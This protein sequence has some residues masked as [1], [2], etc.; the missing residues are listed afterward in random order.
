MISLGEKVEK[1]DPTAFNQS[2]MKVVCIEDSYAYNWAVGK[3]YWAL[4]CCSTPETVLLQAALPT[5]TQTGLSEGWKCESCGETLVAQEITP[6]AGHAVTLG[7]A[8]YETTQ[9]ESISVP[10]V[11]SCGGVCG[12]DVHWCDFS[13]LS[14]VAENAVDYP[15]ELPGGGLMQVWIGEDEAQAAGCTVIVHAADQ[16]ILPSHAAEVASEAFA[17]VAAAEVI[18]PE[19]MVSIGSRAFAQCEGLALVTIPD[20]VKWIAEDAFEETD[21]VVI[22]CSENSFAADY[23]QH[24]GLVWLVP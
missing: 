18:L 9:G 11:L 6:A 21:G 12:L 17:G 3:G 14:G 22:L 8:S 10:F 2:S 13:G 24:K 19:G 20:T 7:A 5:C 23:A 4:C 1:V 16:L 15:A